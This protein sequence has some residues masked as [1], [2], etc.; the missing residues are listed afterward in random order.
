ML[1]LLPLALLAVLAGCDAGRD[2]GICPAVYVTHSIRVVDEAGVA[3]PDLA[4]RSV[5]VETGEVL[6]DDPGAG[7]R[8]ASGTYVVASDHHGRFLD[9]HGTAVR[10][11]AENAD[12]VATAVYVFAPGECN[13]ERRSGPDEVVA[14]RR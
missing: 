12:Y 8:R 10:F 7:D 11:E 2:D 6:P 14:R 3:L 4:A 9:R 13:L 5:V 1:R